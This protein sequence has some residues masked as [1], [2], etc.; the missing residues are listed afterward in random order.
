MPDTDKTTILY[1]DTAPAVGGSVISLLE[2]LKGLDKER[3]QPL[4][5]CFAE[6]PYV[7]RYE[8]AGAH[9]VAWN[10]YGSPDYRPSWAGA[11]RQTAP[12]QRWK[13]GQIG[14]R[15]YHSLGFGL[16]LA[17]RGLPRA[18]RL[19]SIARKNRAALV[20]TNIR[21]GH[22]RE[23][24]IAAR[25]GRLPCVCHVRH[26]ETL[27][28]FDRRVADTVDQFIYI[29]QAVRESHLSSGIGQDRG[30]VVYNGLNI[31]DWNREL[32]PARGRE[33]LG[34]DPQVPLVGI[35][36]RLD[37]WKGQPVFLRAMARLG[38][39][40]PEVRGVLVGD[41]PPELPAYRQELEQLAEQLGLARTV[42]FVPF[43]TELAAVM[44]ALDVAVLASTSP[45]PFGR[46]LIEAM[47]AGKPVVAS[48]SGASRE[49][50]DDGQQGILFPPGD[51]LALANALNRLLSDRSLAA[52]MGGR[53]Q[54]RAAERFDSA[55]YV[56]GVEAV[57]RDV[58][59]KHQP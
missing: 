8:Q 2:L 34:V 1:L 17:R 14:G 5:V 7:Q 50:V 43:Q 32:N 35:V 39:T 11:V 44:S 55:Q 37:S 38:A 13:E 56:A 9:V 36:G 21:V 24:I 26:Q 31:A 20:H 22:D 40:M 28:W 29:S 45:E 53:G 4:V 23:G 18:T 59:A 30:R 15:L 27:G 12:V 25:L 46:V 41:A 33:L 51:D 57:Y 58:L 42:S 16:W 6:H 48:D 49:I 3:Y 47:A 52:E 54:R 19:L 10:E